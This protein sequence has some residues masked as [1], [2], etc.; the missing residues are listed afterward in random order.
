MDTIVA[1]EMAKIAPDPIAGLVL[2][3][4]NATADL[5][6]RALHRPRQQAEAMAGGGSWIATRL[7]GRR[8]PHVAT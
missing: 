2:P 1:V 4:Y 7:G 3:S 6:E 8:W 5:P